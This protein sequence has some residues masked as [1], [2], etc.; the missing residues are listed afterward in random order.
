MHTIQRKVVIYTTLRIV[1]YLLL[2]KYSCFIFG[3]ENRALL[4]IL[5]RYMLFRAAYIH[6]SLKWHETS[7]NSRVIR[8]H[9]HDT[10]GRVK[11]NDVYHFTLK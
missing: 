5:K 10:N 7:D 6:T 3:T 2:W 4:T 8:A 11:Y 9:S 1:G